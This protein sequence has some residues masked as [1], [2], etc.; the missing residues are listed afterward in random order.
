[1]GWIQSKKGPLSLFQG[2]PKDPECR[3]Q[4]LLLYLNRECPC[5]QSPSRQ[6]NRDPKVKVSGSSSQ[7]PPLSLQ[8]QEIWFSSDSGSISAKL[9][10]CQ[11]YLSFRPWCTPRASCP[12][13]QKRTGCQAFYT[14]LLVQTFVFLCLKAFAFQP[15]LLLKEFDHQGAGW[16]GF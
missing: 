10:I 11:R 7:T 13:S 1:M 3:P 16:G 6:E 5:T 8:P 2:L 9:Q 4:D 15:G 12:H 14:F